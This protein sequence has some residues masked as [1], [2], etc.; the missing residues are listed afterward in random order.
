VHTPE[1]PRRCALIPS[2]YILMSLLLAAFAPLSSA[3]ADA[4]DVW[5]LVDTSRLTLTVKRGKDTVKE[6]ENIA[7]GSNGPTLAKRVNDETTPLGDFRIARINPRS[8]FRVFMGFDYPTM[9]HAKRALADGRLG[10]EE[11]LE[12]NNAWLAKQPP[13]QNTTLGGNLGIH[14]LGVGDR[15]IH[16]RFNWTEGCIAV[17]NEQIDELAHWVG[18]GTLVSVR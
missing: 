1:P 6:Y 8:R 18:V 11:Y 9:E 17:T 15:K 2:R 16:G 4:E 14:G 13:P 10:P 7:I 5:L 3:G 12:I